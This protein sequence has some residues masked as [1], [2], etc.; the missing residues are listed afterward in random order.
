MNRSQSIFS[1]LKNNQLIA[2][3]S[4][5]D[6][7]DCVRLYETLHPLGIVI[8]VAFRTAAAADGIKSIIEKYPD[9][10]LLAGTIL[11]RDQATKAIKSGVA[12]I[13]SADYIPEVVEV[14]VEHDILCAPGGLGDV[15]KQLVLKA[16]LYGCSL[17]ELRQQYP[18]QWIHKLFPAITSTTSFMG[19]PKAWKGP[20]Q[21]LSVIYTGGINDGNFKQVVEMDPDGIFCGSALS[22]N[23]HDSE[24]LL[25]NANRWKKIIE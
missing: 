15:G 5:N 19:L 11:T 20:F 21:G 8:E 25:E 9:A 18:Y 7:D 23:L 4:P 14:C 12:G 2:L 24:S 10:L 13:V 6:P 22:K 1:K 17:E 3:L 16:N